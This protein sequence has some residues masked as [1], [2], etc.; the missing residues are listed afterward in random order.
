MPDR[1]RVAV[2]GGGITGLATAYFLQQAGVAVTLIEADHRLGGKIRTDTLAGVPVEAGPDAFLARVP[3]AV[4]LCRDLGLGDELVAPA[5]GT[6]FIWTGGRL[7]PLPGRH[8]LGVPTGL[9]PLVRSGVLSPAGVA[10][11][12]L[13]LVL[14]Q[15]R[16]GDD[17]SVADV[18]GRRMGHEVLDR[19]VGPLVGGINAGDPRRLSLRSTAPQLADGAA[20]HRSLVLGL[21]RRPPT[22]A[23]AAGPAFLSLDGGLQ[24]LVD[25]LAEVLAPA[26][27]IRLGTTVAA[28][29]REGTGAQ[30]RIV[31]TSGERVD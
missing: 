31:T 9:G 16:F 5:S 27:D 4:E 14:P 10:R 7:R 29:E 30:W 22:A 8:V 26:T 12:A 11:A 18:I 6:A 21:R 24:R 25:R 28:V 23:G 19:L 1:R 15:S 20:R 13:D 17:P 3:S 2:V